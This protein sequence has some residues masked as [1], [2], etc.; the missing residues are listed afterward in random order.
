[1]FCMMNVTFQCPGNAE[2]AI[3]HLQALWEDLN[4]LIAR[5]HPQ[6]Q[7]AGIEDEV[8]PEDIEECPETDAEIDELET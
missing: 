8:S 4:D 6:M 7:V 3:P 5:K 1:M 2:T